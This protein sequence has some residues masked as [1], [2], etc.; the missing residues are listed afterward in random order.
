MFCSRVSTAGRLI[1]PH[2]VNEKHQCI[3]S[4]PKPKFGVWR[5]PSWP[6]S[7]SNRKKCFLMLQIQVSRSQRAG[8]Q[9]IEYRFWGTIKRS[10]WHPLTFSETLD[11]SDKVS[12]GT[13]A[14]H[15][16]WETIHFPDHI[17][18][19]EQPHA[20]ADHLCAVFTKGSYYYHGIEQRVRKQ[21]S[22]VWSSQQWAEGKPFL[23]YLL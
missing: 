3:W 4:V 14:R 15:C 6:V 11:A 1:S 19:Y 7:N 22:C 5:S 20:L 13:W 17:Q 21:E 12:W 10:S 18:T 2:R 9:C 16:Y 23:I 8:K